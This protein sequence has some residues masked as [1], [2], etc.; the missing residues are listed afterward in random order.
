M[1]RFRHIAAK[2]IKRSQIVFEEHPDEIERARA[3]RDAVK[4]PPPDRQGN[5]AQLIRHMKLS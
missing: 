3:E 5:V 4:S 2:T 1:K